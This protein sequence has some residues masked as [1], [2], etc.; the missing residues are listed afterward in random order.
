[1][2]SVELILMNSNEVRRRSLKLWSAIPEEFFFHKGDSSSMNLLEQVRHILEAEYLYLEMLK[3]RKSL[4]YSD[5]DPNPFNTR[6]L[7][8]VQEEI[9]FAKPYRQEFLNFIMALNSSDLENITIDRS[10][11]GYTRNLGDMLTRMAYHEAVHAGQLLR[12]LRI[13][14]IERPHLWD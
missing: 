10:D 13:L 14:D 9:N 3:I 6:K 1:M 5:E 12:D 4:P 7:S 2:N 11:V 8:T